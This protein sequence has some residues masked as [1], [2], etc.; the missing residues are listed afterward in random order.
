MK[1]SYYLT[2]IIFLLYSCKG[3]NKNTKIDQLDSDKKVI[4]T[5]TIHNQKFK[6]PDAFLVPKQ[7]IEVTNSRDTIIDIGRKGTK[8]YIPQN[9]FVD[10]EGN[11]IK[12][13]VK[14][15]FQEYKNS[16]EMAFSLI[17]MTYKKKNEQFFFNSSGMF[18]IQGVCNDKKIYI[19]K[20]K[21]IKV[22]YYLAKKNKDIDFYRLKSDSSNWELV[23]KIEKIP[24]VKEVKKIEIPEVIKFYLSIPNKHSYQLSVD[25]NGQ[26]QLLADYLFKVYK[27]PIKLVKYLKDHKESY[28]S[29]RFDIDKESNTLKNIRPYTHN[30]TTEFNENLL[31][32]VKSVGKCTLKEEKKYSRLSY[33]EYSYE[34]QFRLVNENVD[35]NNPKLFGGCFGGDRSKKMNTLLGDGVAGSAGH[36]YPDIVKGLNVETFGVYNCDQIFQIENLVSFNAT[37]QDLNGGKI[38]NPKVL[39]VID[40]DFN[41]AFSFAPSQFKCNPQSNTVLLLF[42]ESG[43]L[44]LFDKGLMKKLKIPENRDVTFKMKDVTKLIT[45]TN[46][47]SKH[48]GINK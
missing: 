10:Q 8:L 46:D 13:K 33:D 42:S 22:D 14:L 26:N 4:V 5:D 11:I 3:D 20:N 39:S 15:T 23:S 7:I 27:A 18:S 2:L 29:V 24:I 48:L 43:Q 25:N 32:L 47:L 41:G 31:E 17:P 1:N 36:T 30:P 12:T 6:I 45:S 9:A 21:S 44:Y 38:I 19:A 16:A 28:F 34:L 37:Y 35:L 40:L